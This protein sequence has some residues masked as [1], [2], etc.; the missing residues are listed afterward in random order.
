MFAGIAGAPLGTLLTAGAV[1]GAFA[2]F[3]YLGAIEGA[4]DVG[5]EVAGAERLIVRHRA[6]ILLPLP[7]TLGRVLGRHD[8]VDAVTH[9]T[10]FGGVY[11]DPRHFFPQFAVEP[12]GYRRVYPALRLAPEAAAA[13]EARRDAVV[14]GRATAERFG[15]EVGD[16]VAL[17]ATLWPRADGST[18]WEF[19]IAGIFE[20]ADRS[21]DLTPLL[22]RYDFFDANRHPGVAGQVGWYVVRAAAPETAGALARSIDRRFA[23]SPNETRTEGELAFVASFARQIGD[24][25]RVLHGITALVFATTLVLVLVAAGRKARRRAADTALLRALGVSAPRLVAL[26]L[27]ESGLVIGVSALAGLATA[28]ALVSRGD[29]SGGALPG[30]VFSAAHGVA[31]LAIAACLAGFAAVPALATC[32]RPLAGQLL[33]RAP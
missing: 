1:A 6:S 20:G 8:G 5:V 27:A 9:A 18:R 21:V 22:L 28:W 29:P 17:D 4:L 19:S 14:V 3:G 25:G 16:R 7:E 31:G 13:W 15:W 11:R 33:R 24:V 23:N 10:W 2:L 26:A 12:R 32:C 30:F